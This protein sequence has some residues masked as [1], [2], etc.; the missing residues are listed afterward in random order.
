MTDEIDFPPYLR[1]WLDETFAEAPDPGRVNEAVTTA[2]HQTPQ[3]RGWLPRLGAGRRQTMLAAT[4][5]T[6]AVVVLGIGGMSWVAQPLARQAETMPGAATD[7]P[8]LPP[9]TGPARNGLIAYAH[10]GDI[11]LGD[12][13]TGTTGPIVTGPQYDSHPAFS[14]DGSRLAFVRAFTYLVV[15]RSDG[16]DERV[17]G[18]VGGA[19]FAWTPDSGSLVVGTHPGLTAFD[20]AGEA[21]PRPLTPPL[22]ERGGTGYFPGDWQIAWSFRPPSGDR[23]LTVD[24]SGDAPL[25]VMDP[26][27][28]D[29]EVLIEASWM[30]EMGYEFVDKDAAWSPDASRIAFTVDHDEHYVM[31]ADGSGLRLLGRNGGGRWSPDGSKIAVQRFARIEPGSSDSCPDEWYIDFCAAGEW[32]SIID[33]ETAT[34]RFLEATYTANPAEVDPAYDGPTLKGWSWSPD[35]RSIVFAPGD[36]ARLLTVDVE[37]GAMTALPWETDSVASWQRVAAD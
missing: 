32:I 15:V 25:S 28:T 5:V 2:V 21:A 30:A 27:G 7:E 34:E 31:K 1:A 13:I 37:T 11:F 22:P 24:W 19:P 10:D 35:G 6:A 20:A 17:I 9:P 12:P 3:R 14:P 23:I 18:E 29:V 36:A 33:V 26:D 4:G 8:R 16:S